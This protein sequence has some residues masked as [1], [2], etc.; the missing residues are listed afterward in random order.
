M[1]EIPS[2]KDNKCE[3]NEALRREGTSVREKDSQ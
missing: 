1:R 2:E 3:K